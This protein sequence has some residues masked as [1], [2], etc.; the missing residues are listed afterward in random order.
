MN[1]WGRTDELDLY[2]NWSRYFFHLGGECGPDTGRLPVSNA[3]TIPRT[4]ASLQKSAIR[5]RGREIPRTIACSES[6]RV[7]CR[8][9]DFGQ[10]AAY[11]S[12]A[13]CAD[14]MPRMRSEGR[15]GR[16]SAV[17]DSGFLWAVSPK[18]G[19]GRRGLSRGEDGG[20]EVLPN[21]LPLPRK[22]SQKQDEPRAIRMSYVI[23]REGTTRNQ[24]KHKSNS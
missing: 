2:V 18:N 16:S 13:R 12:Y 22:S 1:A 6:I 15:G 7:E 4:F 5:S 24:T 21:L 23:E 19:P 11:R 9:R 10:T 14:A 17:H 20:G 8:G 3:T